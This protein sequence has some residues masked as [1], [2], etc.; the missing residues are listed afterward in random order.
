MKNKTSL[1]IAHRLSTIIDANK[2]ILLFLYLKYRSI[3][4]IKDKKIIISFLPMASNSAIGKIKN[5]G[6]KIA[7]IIK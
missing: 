5:I 4:K 3:N 7:K 1:V 6:E 2:I